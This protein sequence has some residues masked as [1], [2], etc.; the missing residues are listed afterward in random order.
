MDWTIGKFTT[1]SQIVEPFGQAVYPSR[2]KVKQYDKEQSS[3]ARKNPHLKSAQSVGYSL[4]WGIRIP[5]LVSLPSLIP[6]FRASG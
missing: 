3:I 5:N 4:S 2:C 1:I 6:N